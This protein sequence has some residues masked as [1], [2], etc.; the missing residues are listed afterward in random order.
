M[1][2]EQFLELTCANPVNR[3][4]LERLPALD[5][6][7]AW[8]VSGSLFQTIWNAMTG[9]DLLHGIR[10]YD[11]FYFDPD[12]SWEAEDR[13]IRRCAE[14]FADLGAAVEVR[15]QARVHQ[16]YHAKFGT[17]YP[18]L[19]STTE[20]IDRFLAVACMVGV[21]PRGADFEVY[22]PHGLADTEAMVVRPNRCPNFRREFYDDKAARWKALWPELKVVPAVN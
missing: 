14:A 12:M 15:N 13:V 3:L 1:L 18:P 19:R 9:R 8:L 7:D 21:R 6:P 16:W 17:D 22:A 5:L 11:V 4:I 20:G 2:P 10:D